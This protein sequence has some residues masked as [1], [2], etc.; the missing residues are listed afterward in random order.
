MVG[1]R[2]AADTAGR[3]LITE[4]R[5]LLGTRLLAYLAETDTRTI[6]EWADGMSALP[7]GTIL[8]RLHVALEAA[9]LLTKLDSP[10]VAQTWFQGRNPVLA[11]Q[12]PAK[13]LRN[14]HPD[15]AR[16]L[17]LDAAGQFTAHGT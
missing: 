7:A 9:Q 1:P 14:T 4:L 17:I 13:V 10:A 3:A 5:S 15:R 11:D 12:S 16:V 2:S 8:D 6:R